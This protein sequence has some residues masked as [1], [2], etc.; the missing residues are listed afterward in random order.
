M[1]VLAIG[2]L[3]LWFI[4]RRKR[5]SRTVDG[6][7]KNNSHRW[8]G[9]RDP[10]GGFKTNAPNKRYRSTRSLL[11]SQHGSIASSIGPEF[12][13]GNIGAE[14]K[15]TDG[16][17]V[18][19]SA[20]PVLHHQ[21]SRT[22]PDHTYSASSSSTN[23]NEFG[24]SGARYSIQP[25]IDSSAVY[26]PSLRESGQY[27]LASDVLRSHSMST[28]GTH[29]SLSNTSAISSPPLPP[30]SS[31][32]NAS[33]QMHRESMGGIGKKR[34]PAPVY[35]PSEDEPLSS[36]SAIFSIPALQH[37]KSELSFPELSHKNSFGPG[38]IEGK[39]L[40]YLIPD[41]PVS[42]H[43][44]SS[45]KKKKKLIKFWLFFFFF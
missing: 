8:K 44:W 22:R 16:R 23:L 2:L 40:H 11:T 29:H 25:S 18:A 37:S 19:L 17:G 39:P 34:K 12:E 1:A 32:L 43:S 20:L 45:G 28:T 14:K 7:D 24:K 30:P 35:D 38:G 10:R 27:M 4:L 3:L 15:S 41:M 13:G 5:G 26:P 42:Q 9:F 21:T 6:G 33:K 31:N 36:T